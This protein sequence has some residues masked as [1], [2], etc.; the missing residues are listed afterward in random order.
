MA[1]LGPLAKPFPSVGGSQEAEREGM[2]SE[3][4][5]ICRPFEAGCGLPLLLVLKGPLTHLNIVFFWCR[6]I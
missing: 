1:P 4:S 3:R 6:L 5:N 2:T